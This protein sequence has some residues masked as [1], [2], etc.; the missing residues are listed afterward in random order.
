[1]A[2]VTLSCHRA[3]LHELETRLYL[4]MGR[5]TRYAM[6]SFGVDGLPA[7]QKVMIMPVTTPLPT[8][9]LYIDVLM[10]LDA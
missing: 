9:R 6:R 4:R 1:M 5:V 7:L 3:L 2:C 8:T 10:T